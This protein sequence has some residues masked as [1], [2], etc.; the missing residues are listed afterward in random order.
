MAD[1]EDKEPSADKA[2]PISECEKPSADEEEEETV[3]IKY[4]IGGITYL[5]SED[6][7]LYDMKTHDCVGI[8]NE[9]TKKIDEIP[10]EDEDD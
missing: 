6:N 4:E 9:L 2:K 8:W 10:D 1:S 7:V 5:K 3:V